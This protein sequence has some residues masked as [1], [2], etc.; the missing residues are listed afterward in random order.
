MK[1]FVGIAIT[2]VFCLSFGF[3][4]F[5]NLDASSDLA[6][7]SD[8][9]MR[10]H[11]AGL[12]MAKLA[13]DESGTH[14]SCSLSDCDTDTHTYTHQRYECVP[15]KPN[16]AARTSIWNYKEE[17]SWCTETYDDDGELIRCEFDWSVVDWHKTCIW[18]VGDCPTDT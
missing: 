9:E 3:S 8:S 4:V 5:Q 6:P 11:T 14:A 15:C 13:S 18:R 12:W 17:S 10:Q 7:L 16:R 2:A 1:P